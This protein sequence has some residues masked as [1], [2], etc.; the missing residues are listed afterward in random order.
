MKRLAAVAGVVLAA[1]LLLIPATDA[2]TIK[3]TYQARY[4][5]YGTITVRQFTDGTGK[6]ILNMYAMA[7]GRTYAFS[8][9]RGR[10]TTSITTLVRPGTL[11]VNA[12]GKMGRTWTFSTSQMR[13]IGPSL[14]SGNLVAI[15]TAGS[16]RLCRTLYVPTA[17][18]PSP[19][20]SPMPSPAATP[21]AGVTANVSAHRF[22]YGPLLTPSSMADWFPALKV[23]VAASATATV[24]AGQNVYALFVVP[25]GGS[26]TFKIAS[27]SGSGGWYWKWDPQYNYWDTPEHYFYEGQFFT[28]NAGT[29]WAYGLDYN[30]YA[31]SE[32][33]TITPTA[34]T[35][36]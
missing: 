17:F 19:S 5:P 25:P 13:T 16:S 4:G 20:S 23:G 9:A 31:G 8:L 22:G 28:L 1:T 11:K 24:A 15:L 26:V 14:S 32:T 18:A 7:P 21:T 34:I 33:L 27:S 35:R 30:T 6:A 12:A 29:T 3:A 2:A 10:C 36:P